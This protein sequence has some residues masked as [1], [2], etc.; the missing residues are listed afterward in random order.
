M[1]ADEPEVVDVV[2]EVNKRVRSAAVIL[3]YKFLFRVTSTMQPH[4]KH[5]CEKEAE[6]KTIKSKTTLRSPTHILHTSFELTDSHDPQMAPHIPPSSLPYTR[7][8][9]SSKILKSGSRYPVCLRKVRL[10]S[11]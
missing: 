1:V 7:N 2:A 10:Q 6:K 3:V 5:G 4:I 9:S 8:I 11:L